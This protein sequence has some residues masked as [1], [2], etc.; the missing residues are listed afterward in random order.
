MGPPATKVVL[1]AMPFGPAVFPALGLSILKPLLERAGFAVRVRYATLAFSELIGHAAYSQIAMARPDDLI[2]D[3]IFADTL[4]PDGEAAP[5]SI[6]GKPRGNSDHP[7]VELVRRARSLVPTF[8]DALVDEVLADEPQIVGFTSTFAQHAAS[9]AAARAIKARHPDVAILFGGANCETE[10]GAELARRF[11]FVDAVVSGEGEGVI[12]ELARRVVAGR[13]VAD[14]PGVFAA[15]D[16]DVPSAGVD[17]GTVVDMNALPIP[18]FDDYFAAVDALD[19]DR[20]TFPRFLIVEASRGCWWGAKHHCTFC[21]LNG[22]RMGFRSKAP[23]RF[24]DELAEL[25][26]RYGVVDVTAADNIIDHN[27]FGTMLPELARRGLGLRIF[28]EIKANVKRHH[29]EAL[30]AAGVTRVQPGIE[31]LDTGVLRLMRKGVTGLQNVQTLKLCKESG[32]EVA[33]NL[34][35]GFPNEEPAAYARMAQLIP[36]LAHLPPPDVAGQI[37]MD[38]FSPFF[39]DPAA[40]GMV[41]VRPVPAYAYVYGGETESL[42][43]LAYYFDFD[44]ADGRDVASYT[45]EFVAAARRWKEVYDRSDLCTLDGGRDVLLVDR[46]AIAKQPFLVLSGLERTVYLACEEI[47]DARSI[48]AAATAEHPDATADDVLSA[49][50]RFVANGFMLEEAGRYLSLAVSLQRGAASPA[51]RERLEAALSR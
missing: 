6:N 13:S 32:I 7:F 31:S 10:M 47:A 33:W 28:F 5:L 50:A 26:A 46:R 15:S 21:G 35:M 36:L 18:D 40:F 39:N 49:C 45:S 9:L 14:L 17:A 25:S 29:V 22:S 24:V 12:V 51:L 41:N 30:R 23:V 34:L 2:G 3:W 8:L 11:P 20:A 38:R 1:V 48:V 27:Y 19:P 37:R 43:R 44:Y 42:R 16:D 4:S